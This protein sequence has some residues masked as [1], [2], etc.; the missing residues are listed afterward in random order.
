MERC[1]DEAEECIN[2]HCFG[3]STDR[4]HEH[5]VALLKKFPHT[6]QNMYIELQDLE[7]LAPVDDSIQEKA[8]KYMTKIGLQDHISNDDL[9]RNRKGQIS[10]TWHMLS[11]KPPQTQNT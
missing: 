11:E 5:L 6:L 9:R 2:L 10:T 4:T 1:M 3:M 7:Q 8:D